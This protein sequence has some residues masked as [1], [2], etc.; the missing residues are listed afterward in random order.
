MKQTFKYLNDNK[1]KLKLGIQDFDLN[2]V[3]I[4]EPCEVVTFTMEV[5][6]DE[7]IFIK[8]WKHDERMLI[9][10]ANKSVWEINK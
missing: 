6:E 4:V 10:T 1:K 9:K 3:L 8:T 2:N 5:E 7:V